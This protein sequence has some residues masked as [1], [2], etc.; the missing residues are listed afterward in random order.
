M[1]PAAAILMRIADLSGSGGAGGA[2]GT[3][4]CVTGGG[5]AGGASGSRGGCGCPAQAASRA[6][7]A[8]GTVCRTLITKADTEYV[9]L[10]DAQATAQHVQLVKIVGRPDVNAVVVTV[11]DLDTLYV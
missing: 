9:D 6:A 10:S 5:A 11:V 4:G 8:T 1:S 7:R 2:A 3:T